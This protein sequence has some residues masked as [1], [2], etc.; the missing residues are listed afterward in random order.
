MM[1]TTITTKHRFLPLLLLGTLVTTGCSSTD[2]FGD[3]TDGDLARRIELLNS[4]TS[5]ASGAISTDTG[6]GPDESVPADAGLSWYASEAMRSNAEIRAARQRVERLRE[7]VPQV[8]SL[9][10]PMASVTFGE[11]A[12]TAAGQVDYIM[13]VQQSLPFPGTLDARGEVARQ[14]VVESLAA[15]QAVIDRV[16]GDVGRAYWSYDGAVREVDVLKRSHDLLTQIE[17]AVRARVR[18]GAANQADLLR[19]SRELA[20]L[21]NRLSELNRRQRTAVAML[22]RL[23]SRPTTTEWPR[24]TSSQWTS[25]EL[26]AQQLRSQGMSRNP[27]VAVSQARVATFRKRLA[28]ARQERLPDFVFGVQYAAVGDNG[29]AMSANGDDQIAGTVG[30][31]IPLWSG[32]YDAAEREALRGMGEALAEVQAAQDRVAFDIDEALARIEA[33]EQT[34]RRLRERMMPDARQIIDVALASYRTGDVDFLQLL[35]DWQTLLDDQ[36]EETRIVADLHRAMADL[37]QAVGGAL[38]VERSPDDVRLRNPG[39]QEGG[40]RGL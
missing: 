5:T 7:R 16:R 18:V 39:D 6:T 25:L 31:S 30:V 38:H 28:L 23:T 24:T 19:I 20:A 13:G 35:D 10:D 37:E 40:S 12:Q 4:E 8:T 33:N 1:A 11:L 3:W 17:A 34:L 15:L 22:A 27:T 21:E 36:L 26:D 9:P 2:P 14:E 29:L 32:K